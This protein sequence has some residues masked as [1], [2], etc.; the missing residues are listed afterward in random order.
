L[1]YCC[2][3]KQLVPVTFDEDNLTIHVAAFDFVGHFY[4]LLTD[5]LLVFDLNLLD[6]NATDPFGKYI[7]PQRRLSCFNSGSW[8]NNAWNNCI[9]PENEW[10]CPIIFG[11][12]ETLVGSHL[13]WTSCAPLNFTLF[14]FSKELRNKPL[15]WRTLG[16]LYDLTMHGKSLVNDNPNIKA[17][18]FTVH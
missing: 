1:Q 9:K 11:C 7:A 2:Q 5:P 16:F 18:K 6:V 10:K 17:K 14:I 4:S 8:Y 13:V 12:D 15:S 3:P